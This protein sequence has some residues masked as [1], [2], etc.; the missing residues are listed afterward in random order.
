MEKFRGFGGIRIE[1]NVVVTDKG[2]KVIGKPI[3]KEIE[4][5]EKLVGK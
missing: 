5:V 3:A 1:D 2:H 4:E